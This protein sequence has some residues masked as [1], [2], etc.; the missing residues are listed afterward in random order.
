MICS[1]I[2][3]KEYHFE[4][5]AGEVVC[6]NIHKFMCRA[7]V[8]MVPYF[9]RFITNQRVSFALEVLEVAYTWPS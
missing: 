2:P 8:P 7:G 9:G 4:A 5:S 3:V 6:K 1:D